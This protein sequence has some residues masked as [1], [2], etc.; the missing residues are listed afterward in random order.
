LTVS[1]TGRKTDFI[2]ADSWTSDLQDSTARSVKLFR[3]WIRSGQ[4]PKPTPRRAAPLG[5][6]SGLMPHLHRFGVL[7][8]LI[9]LPLI[10]ALRLGGALLGRRSCWWF[11]A[12]Y[13][14]FT[15]G[16]ARVAAERR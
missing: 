9:G 12:M 13:A 11:A 3:Q 15:R 4:V 6:R 16:A 5:C 2:L 7:I 10:F 8:V 14:M 1:T